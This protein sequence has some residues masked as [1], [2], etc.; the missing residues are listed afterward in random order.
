MKRLLLV[1]V[2]I[3]VAISGCTEK[4]MASK[5]TDELKTLSISSAENLTGFGVKSTMVQTIKLNSGANASDSNITTVTESA[6]TTA[7]VNLADMQAHATGSTQNLA[8]VAGKTIGN[9]S[10]SADVYQMKNITYVKDENGNWTRLV[11]P[12]SPDE[13]WG[14]DSN[15]QIKNMA[16]TF[17]LS[18]TED[19]GSETV[20]GVDAYKIKIVTGSSD[21][22]ILYNAAFSTAAKI[23]QYPLYMPSIN[24]TEL[25][26]T[27]KIEKT[28]WISKENNMPVKYQS[29]MSFT[30]TPE[31]VGSL[32]PNTWQMTMLNKSIQMGEISVVIESTDKYFDFNR[33]KEIKPPAEA[34]SAPSMNPDTYQINES[35]QA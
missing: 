5:S 6:E 4:E 1:L 22:L 25:N 9:S 15:N 11:D 10:T 19:L 31:I 28:I 14:G 30:V 18:K 3:A 27:G 35:E 17:N 8:E 13:V 24:K 7:S 21:Y 20:D 2:L 16:E 29:T 34:L 12:R 32:N 33:P 26:E 23:V